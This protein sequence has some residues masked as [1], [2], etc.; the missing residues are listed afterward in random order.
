MVVVTVLIDVTFPSRIRLSFRGTAKNAI[1]ALLKVQFETSADD[2]NRTISA[3]HHADTQGNETDLR[4]AMEISRIFKIVNWVDSTG[5]GDCSV[6]PPLPRW[7]PEF[8]FRCECMHKYAC[9]WQVVLLLQ[10]SVV[11]HR[12]HLCI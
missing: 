9:I 4:L 8:L 12:R 10:F 11:L 2:I 5:A 3:W 1:Y 6:A 7:G